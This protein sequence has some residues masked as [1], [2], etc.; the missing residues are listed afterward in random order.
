M[1]RSLSTI[2]LERVL[3]GVT[4]VVFFL[5]TV[6]TVA[7]PR[8]LLA[9]AL[10]IGAL[11]MIALLAMVIL[12]YGAT[13]EDHPLSRLLDRL[14]QGRTQPAGRIL[15]HVVTGLQ[16]LRSRRAIALI[17]LYTLIIWGSNA[18]FVWLVVRAFHIAVPLTA[19][20]LLV[21]VLNLGMAVPSSPG[22]IGQFEA[23]MV[24]TLGLYAVHRAPALAAAFA[25]HA[26]AFV[27]VTIIG[28]VYI[29]RMGLQVT[30]QMVR[31]SATRTG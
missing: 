23:L 18:L 4:L 25:L 6:P 26:L 7:F 11:F 13:R 20:V 10:L 16:A 24:L 15:R 28:L 22:Y 21:S 5:L 14:E 9:P 30:L 29:A 3:D 27:P 19:G 12:A 8:Q 31:A 2:A 17:L 1:V